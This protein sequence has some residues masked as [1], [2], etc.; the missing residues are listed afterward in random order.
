[1]TNRKNDEDTAAGESTE[2]EALRA[3]LADAQAQLSAQSA[4]PEPA[5]DEPDPLKGRLV[6]ATGT[7]VAVPA[8][9]VAVTTHHFDESVGQDVPVVNRF[10]LN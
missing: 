2:L 3:Q 9:G 10:V 6:L 8:A 1:M 5:A 7:I 4:D